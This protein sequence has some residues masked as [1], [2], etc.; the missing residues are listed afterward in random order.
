MTS[1]FAAPAPAGIGAALSSARMGARTCLVEHRG[2]LGGIWTAGLLSL[3]L[4]AKDKPGIVAEIRAR[5]HS[6][7][8]IA[9]VRDLYDPEEMKFLLEEMCAEAGIEVRLHTK[10]SATDVQDRHLRH[11]VLEGK[12]GRFALGASCFIDT[13]GDGDLAALA[14][15]GF[16]LGRS[17]DGLMQPMSLL[18]LIAGVPDE[19]RGSNKGANGSATCVPKAQFLRMLNEAGDDP[20]YAAPK[21]FPLPNGLCTLMANHIYEK[22]GLDSRDLTVATLTAR[23]EIHSTVRAMKKFWPDVRLVATAE[24]MGIREGRRIHGLYRITA[25]DVTKGSR[26]PDGVTDVRFPVDVHSVKKAEGMGYSNMGIATNAAGYD[27]PLRSLIARD[28]ENLAMAGRCISG[29]FHAHA[30]YRVTGNAV[31]TGEAAGVLCA[32]ATREKKA[33]RGVAAQDLLAALGTLRGV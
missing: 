18:A 27:I 6:R 30:S 2:C 3:I 26:F 22:T 13:T 31:S 4:D 16:D 29:D 9:E 12:E 23:R 24:A 1:L 8:A 32:I 19:V 33:L 25:E 5:L 14:G 28:V 21:L 7:N 15:C 10:V 17:S 11:I 20:S